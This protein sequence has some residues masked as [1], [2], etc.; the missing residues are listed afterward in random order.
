VSEGAGQTITT[1][2]DIEQHV[3]AL[4]LHPV[5]LWVYQDA[6]PP[7]NGCTLKPPP[8][9]SSGTPEAEVWQYAQSPRRRSST[10]ACA[11][12]YSAD[13]NCYVNE[14][15]LGGLHLDLSVATSG[16]PSHGR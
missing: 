4:H 7:S 15:G 14:P 1:A 6:C 2:Q 10:L 9:S 8:F 12:T 13:G 3:A 5:V 11:R 16:D